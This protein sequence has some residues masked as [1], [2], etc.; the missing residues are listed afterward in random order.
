MPIDTA[1]TPVNIIASLTTLLVHTDPYLELIAHQ[2]MGR[3]PLHAANSNVD[4]ANAN[5]TD[6]PEAES[7][8][9]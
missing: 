8:S 9:D 6:A 3:N 4:S 5:G 7:Q 2:L 1:L